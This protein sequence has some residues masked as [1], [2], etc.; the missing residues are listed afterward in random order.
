MSVDVHDH[1]YKVHLPGWCQGEPGLIRDSPRSE[2]N[3][4]L[5]RLE[6]GLDQVTSN[7]A[8]AHLLGS[9]LSEQEASNDLLWRHGQA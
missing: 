1:P 6:H 2:R 7:A 8:P 5:R 3:L 4:L 9:M